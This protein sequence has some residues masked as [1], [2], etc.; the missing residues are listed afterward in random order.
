MLV[1]DSK[2]RATLHEITNHPWMTKGFTGPPENHLPSREPLQLP[3]DPRIIQDMT[4][5]DFGGPEV[6]ESQLTEILES[7]EYIRAVRIA[8]QEKEQAAIPKDEKKRGFGFDFYKRRNSTS[9]DTLTN[10]STEALA[11]GADPTNAFH[12]LI[13]VYHLVKEKHERDKAKENPGATALPRTTGDASLQLPDPPK[14]AMTNSTA[15]ETPGEKTGGRS[16]PRAR[17]HG[18]DEINEDIKNLKVSAAS[19]PNSP[20]IRDSTTDGAPYR[21][22]STAAGIL[23]RFSTRRKKEAEKP[24]FAATPLLTIQSPGN[25]RSQRADRPEP[26]GLRKSFSVRRPRNKEK[27][28]IHEDALGA[29]KSQPGH[30]DLLSPPRTADNHTGSPKGLAR[31]SSVNSAEFRRRAQ[32]LAADGPPPPITFKEPKAEGTT[33]NATDAEPSNEEDKTARKEADSHPSFAQ[34]TLRAKSLGHARRESIQARRARR[35]EAQESQGTDIGETN[36]SDKH[37][38]LRPSHDDDNDHDRDGDA[39]GLSTERLE[40][41]ENVKPVFLKGLFSVSTTSTK[42]VSAIRADIIRVLKRLGVE[43]TE[44]RG[45]FSC[46]HYPSIDLKKIVDLP[47]TPHAPHTPALGKSRRISFGN[48][49]G[50]SS[51]DRER[52]REE[53]RE[54][55]RFDSEKS[56]RSPHTPRTRSNRNSTFSYESDNSAESAENGGTA[57]RAVGETSTHVQSELGGSMIL[58]FEIFIVKVPLLSLHGIQ[59]KRLAGGTWQYKSMADQI[60]KGL[61]L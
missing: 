2:Q 40:S 5:F 53:V 3:L 33:P 57:T 25:E 48:F 22:E 8:A 17:T 36:T 29:G 61:R 19:G 31:S 32:R 60:L 44:I 52:E 6:I 59:F 49:M 21:K 41:A 16:R 54:A 15:Y 1:T 45:G 50:T 7:Q 26:S 9:R 11:I 28:A 23:R 4:G 37:D 56:P 34:K 51:A 42:P 38:N 30:S 46:R 35:S 12:P 24:D 20:A 10:M 43:Y 13:S 47:P 39:S 27:E 58:E 14:A 18:E 55:E